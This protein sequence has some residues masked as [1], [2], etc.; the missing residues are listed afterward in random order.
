MKFKAM[1]LKGITYADMA[2]E[3]D[4]DQ[5]T[6]HYWRIKMELPPRRVRTQR[7]WM[8]VPIGTGLSSRQILESVASQIG[9]TK[10]DIEFILIPVEKL[11]S[12]GLIKGRRFEHVVLAAAF[13]YLRSERSG[14]RPLSAERFAG[15]C[16]EYCLTRSVLFTTIRP[17]MAAGLFPR[18]LIRPQTLLE[19]LWKSLQDKFGLPDA[20]KDRI[21]ELVAE[22]KIKYK[23]PSAVLA[24]CTYVACVEASMWITQVEIA[25]F[26]GVTEVT[27]RNLTTIL[28]ENNR[29]VIEKGELHD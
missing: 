17:F 14:R 4:L 24:A 10:N 19:R 16:K 29:S 21:L 25:D 20:M 15:I 27:L 26:F 28:R 22:P 13:L 2:K 18:I 6:L 11:K 8:D 1:F 23:T 3:L 9:I 5:I 12:K 7:S